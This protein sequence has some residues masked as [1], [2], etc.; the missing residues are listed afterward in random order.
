MQVLTNLQVFILQSTFCWSRDY[1]PH[2]IFSGCMHQL[3]FSLLLK[4]SVVGRDAFGLYLEVAPLISPSSQSV[5]DT[6]KDLLLTVACHHLFQAQPE[7]ITAERGER[8]MGFL[9]LTS[10]TGAAT[11]YQLQCR[12]AS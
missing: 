6:C 4:A 11:V 2:S 12:G 10:A 5:G 8:P 9:P 3:C 7:F 1:L